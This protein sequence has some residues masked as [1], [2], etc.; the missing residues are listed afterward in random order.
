[1]TA[2]IEGQSVPLNKD[3]SSKTSPVIKGVW[4]G[5]AG[6]GTLAFINDKVYFVVNRGGSCISATYTFSGKDGTISTPRWDAKFTVNGNKLEYHAS[7]GVLYFTRA[8]K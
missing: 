7:N 8:E 4:N 1:L 5:D 6:W 3:T 2:Q